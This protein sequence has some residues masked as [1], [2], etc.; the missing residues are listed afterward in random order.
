MSTTRMSTN[1][2][3][4]LPARSALRDGLKGAMQ[5]RLWLLWIGATLACALIAALPAW[6]WLADALNYSVHAQAIATGQAPAPLL[7]L[8]MSR[9]APLGV[10]GQSTTIAAILML[11]LSPLLAGATIAAIRP[12]SRAACT[13]ANPT[14]RPGWRAT[15]RATSRLAW[16]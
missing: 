9:N 15:R 1:G 3:T 6:A 10:I 4:S 14:R 2:P 13:K 8:L 11:L 5:W 12:A 16:A 7:D